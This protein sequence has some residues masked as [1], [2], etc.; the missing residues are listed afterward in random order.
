MSLWLSGWRGSRGSIH[1]DSYQNLLVVL[2]GTKDVLLWP[3]A[4]TASL[5]PQQ[6]GGESGNHSEVDI[7]RPDASAYPRFQAALDRATGVTL[8]AGDALYIPEGFWHQVTSGGTTI[9]VNYWRVASATPRPA[10][11]VHAWPAQVALRLQS[12]LG[13]SYGRLLRAPGDGEP[14]RGGEALSLG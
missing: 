11:C 1:Y 5:Y 12:A 3:P 8:R 6:L 2:A 13:K 4:E 10:R 14:G 9:A 7:A